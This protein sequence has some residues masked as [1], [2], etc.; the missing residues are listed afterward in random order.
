[1]FTAGIFLSEKFYK[2]SYLDS[3]GF[4]F[5]FNL[6]PNNTEEL[7]TDAAVTINMC[8]RAYMLSAVFAAYVADL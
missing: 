6:I 1:M 8:Y 5:F 4:F 7:V 3:E 2:K